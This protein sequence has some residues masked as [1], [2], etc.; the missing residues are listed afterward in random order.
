M[1]DEIHIHHSLSQIMAT[2]IMNFFGPRAAQST[3]SMWDLEDVMFAKA[4][5]GGRARATRRGQYKS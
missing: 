3:N 4:E 1:D 5:R 2:N